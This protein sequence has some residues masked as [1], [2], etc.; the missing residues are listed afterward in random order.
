M[1][2]EYWNSQEVSAT[3]LIPFY[4][5]AYAFALAMVPVAVMLLC[6]LIDAMREVIA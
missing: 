4:P 3:I 5:F 1:G 2:L 6:D